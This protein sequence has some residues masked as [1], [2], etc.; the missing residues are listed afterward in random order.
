M[1]IGVSRGLLQKAG[2]RWRGLKSSGQRQNPCGERW[3]QPPR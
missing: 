1:V 2:D 3:L